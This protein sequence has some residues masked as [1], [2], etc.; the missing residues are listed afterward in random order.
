MES[1]LSLGMYEELKR[2]ES[3]RKERER[4]IVDRCK[5]LNEDESA[6]WFLKVYNTNFDDICGGGKVTIHTMSWF[7]HE[8]LTMLEKALRMK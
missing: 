6:Y 2:L 1:K 4:K 5:Q 7:S 3:I 8:G